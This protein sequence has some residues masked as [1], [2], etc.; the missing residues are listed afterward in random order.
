M[1]GHPRRGENREAM[2]HSYYYLNT[3]LDTEATEGLRSSG[4]SF[5]GRGEFSVK[6]QPE[7]EGQVPSLG[8]AKPNSGAQTEQM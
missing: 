5:D 6:P 3:L 2:Q 1:T 8:K 7:P 4:P